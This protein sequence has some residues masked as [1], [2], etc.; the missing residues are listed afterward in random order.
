MVFGCVFM[1]FHFTLAVIDVISPEFTGV[2]WSSPEFTGIISRVLEIVTQM[3]YGI[4]YF[5]E[6]LRNE[7]ISMILSKT[8]MFMII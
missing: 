5:V 2:P 4:Q 6:M 1:R 8:M 3:F 7:E